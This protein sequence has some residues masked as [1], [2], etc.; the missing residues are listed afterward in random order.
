MTPLTWYLMWELEKGGKIWRGHI[1]VGKGYGVCYSC[2]ITLIVYVAW[3][4]GCMIFT[5][6]RRDDL[7]RSNLL[8]SR[9]RNRLGC[10]ERLDKMKIWFDEK[11]R[12]AFGFCDMCA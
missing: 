6:H 2:E 5:D 10:S 3:R 11:F 1:R 7:S 8:P 4:L 12:N 9:L